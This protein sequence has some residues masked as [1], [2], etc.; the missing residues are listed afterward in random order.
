MWDSSRA[1]LSGTIAVVGVV[2]ALTLSGCGSDST[3]TSEPSDTAPLLFTVTSEGSRIKATDDGGYLLLLDHVDNH[4][5]WFTDRPDR[6]SGVLET[7]NFVNSWGAFG[8]EEVPPNAALIA[9]DGAGLAETAVVTLS[10]PQYDTTYRVMM[11][12]IDFVGEAPKFRP[13]PGSEI[14]LGQLSVFIDDAEVQIP[15]QE[16]ASS[17]SIQDWSFHSL[18]VDTTQGKKYVA[19]SKID[20]GQIRTGENTIYSMPA[21]DLVSNFSDH[22]LDTISGGIELVGDTQLSSGD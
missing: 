13:K 10:N 4:S 3:N 19:K 7:G 2:M 17:D 1:I 14:D 16:T 11:A 6:Q 18:S 12:D 21:I 20:A 9:H 8:F 5:I 15:S 22:H